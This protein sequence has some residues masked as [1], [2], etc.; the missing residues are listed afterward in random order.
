ML[1]SRLAQF[2]ISAAGRSVANK[3]A[4][5]HLKSVAVNKEAHAA[6]HAVLGS[7]VKRSQNRISCHPETIAMLS[8]HAGLSTV[9]GAGPRAVQGSPAQA[10]DALAIIR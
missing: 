3:V 9:A 8:L 2:T 4:L 5:L 6:L 1:C 7:G 10:H